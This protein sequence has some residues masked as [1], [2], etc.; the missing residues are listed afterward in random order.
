MGDSWLPWSLRGHARVA[1]V[2]ICPLVPSGKRATAE[3][4]PPA[5]LTALPQAG[6]EDPGSVASWALSRATF[7]G[8]AAFVF[9]K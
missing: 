5:A 7:L 3:G 9:C 1:C 2:S 4:Q 6:G 8:T